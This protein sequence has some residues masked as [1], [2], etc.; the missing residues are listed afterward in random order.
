V[1]MSNI[2]HDRLFKELLTNFFREFMEAFFPQADRLLDYSYLEFLTQE[3]FTDVT[4]G[5]KKYIDILVKPV[6]WV[7]KGM[8]WYMWSLKP[9]R[10][11]TFPAECFG[12]LPVFI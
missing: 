9:R 5:E 1:F 10:A 4:A 2:D 8:S 6:F 3:V 12:I 7:R 11:R